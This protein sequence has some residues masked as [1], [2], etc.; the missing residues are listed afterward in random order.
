MLKAFRFW[1]AAG[2]PA[3]IDL[4]AVASFSE[5]EAPSTPAPAATP[6]PVAVAI[7]DTPEFKEAVRR[8][9]EAAR[10]SAEDAEFATRAEAWFSAELAAGRVI[11]A[12]KDRL[13]KR[14]VRLAMDDR[15]HPAEFAAGEPL[16]RLAEFCSDIARRRPHGLDGEAVGTEPVLPEGSRSLFNG[17]EA[18]ASGGPLTPE[19][20]NALLAATSLGKSILVNGQ[21]N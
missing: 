14:Y 1:K 13:L 5:V 16:S 17:A 7:E 21:R 3:T 6:P 4:T 18:P 11:P 15:D 2:E 9:T 12:D 8:A 10:R 19:R 20:L